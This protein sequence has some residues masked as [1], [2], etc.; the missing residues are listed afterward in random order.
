M[1]VIQNI[2]WFCKIGIL[3]INSYQVCFGD[4]YNI[5]MCGLS[6]TY[7]FI[8]IL[9][10]LLSNIH[11]FPKVREIESVEENYLR[12]LEEGIYNE[13]MKLKKK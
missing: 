13:N 10:T 9:A 2:V 5:F 6:G 1:I 4:K 7:F 3:G 11:L 8:L 12:H